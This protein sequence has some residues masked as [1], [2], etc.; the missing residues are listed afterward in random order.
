MGYWNA[1]LF[2]NDYTLDFIDMNSIKLKKAIEVD[3]VEVSNYYSAAIFIRGIVYMA[4]A[5]NYSA[6]PSSVIELAKAFNDNVEDAI[7]SSAD[8]EFANVL[9]RER[10]AI[11]WFLAS[12]K[13]LVTLY[14][15]P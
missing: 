9:S 15:R 8:E 2:G 12:D 1:E 13:G 3:P 6:V 7:R 10:R 14:P 4:D 11:Q 5:T